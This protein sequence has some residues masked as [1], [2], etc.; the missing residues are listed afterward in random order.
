MASTSPATLLAAG[1]DPRF[2]DSIV[3]RDFSIAFSLSTYLCW[4]RPRNENTSKQTTT[5]IRFLAVAHSINT[6]HT[7]T[8]A[9]THIAW[10]CIVL[11]CP[12]LN[13]L[14]DNTPA[15]YLSSDSEH[16]E[17]T[18]RHVEARAPRAVVRNPRLLPQLLSAVLL[19][20]QEMFSYQQSTF[21][22]ALLMAP[23]PLH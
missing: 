21:A 3:V 11:L 4:M 2:T 10:H 23:T 19:E 7:H 14:L 1:R 13:Q 20:E 5:R 12:V 8:H 18:C 22:P 15:Q 17:Q 6:E 9:Y 16:S